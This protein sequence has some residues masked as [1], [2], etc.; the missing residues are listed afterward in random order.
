MIN[1]T[2]TA[3]PTAIANATV[4]SDEGTTAR[5]AVK[6]DSGIAVSLPFTSPASVSPVKRASV[7]RMTV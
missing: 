5:T 2:V 6:R 7:M 1:A 3:P 4:F